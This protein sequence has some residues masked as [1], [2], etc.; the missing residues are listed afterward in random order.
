M[1]YSVEADR[2]NYETEVLEKSYEMPVLVDFNATWCG[3]CQLL[4]PILEKLV[5][6]YDFVLAKVDI[7]KNPE[8]ASQYGIEGVP[9]V[10]VVTQGETL[11][12]FVGAL[13]EPQLREFLG[14]LN[15][16]SELEKGIKEAQ[17]AIAS[18]DA[19]RAKQIFD[20]LFVKY[21]DSAKLTLEAAQFLV[22]ANKLKEAQEML[23]TI[24]ADRREEYA[25][26]QSLKTLIQFQQIIETPA[27]NEL[28]RQ[29]SKAAQLTLAQD[30]DGALKLF[31]GIVEESRRYRDDGARKAMLS[32]F[33]VL[34]NAHPLTQK[35][36]QELMLALY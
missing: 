18:R 1:G 10:R 17:D 14:Q 28:D 2:G 32:I 21:P 22:R 15:L 5:G 8:L 11:P 13:S 31:L 7:D 3:P 30:Y 9:D 25:R 27:E 23:A 6:E 12:G 35:Y 16:K 20:E 33:S 26:A 29:F 34:G 19:R 24:S 36:Q 4:K